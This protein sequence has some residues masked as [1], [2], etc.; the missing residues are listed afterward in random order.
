MET[1][2]LRRTW[3][4]FAVWLGTAQV[5]MALNV[6]NYLSPRNAGRPTRRDTYFIILHTTEGAAKGS[7]NKVWKNGECHYFIDLDGK[8]YRIIDRD[9]VA[10]HAGRSMW[11]GRTSIDDYSIGIEIVGTYNRDITVAQYKACAELLAAL[12]KIYKV[13]D[14]KVLSHCMVAYGAPNRWHSRSHRGRKRC[15]MFLTKDSTRQKLGLTSKPAYDPDVKAGRL[16]NADPTLAAFVYR[17]GGDAKVDM[18]VIKP[19]EENVITKNRS[20]W[21]VA[22]AQY[23]NAKTVYIFPDGRKLRGNEIRDWKNIP[24]GTRVQMDEDMPENE[25]DPVTELGDGSIVMDVAGDEYND[26]STLYVLAS[27]VVKK[28]SEMSDAEFK[29]LPAG[30]KV[31]LGYVEGGA[32]TPKK[33]AFEICGKR[34]NLPATCYL[35]KDGTIKPGNEIKENE[36]Q[37]GTR[38]FYRK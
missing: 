10:L 14:D 31:L 9:K 20:A 34:W 6:V 15:G 1:Y 24:V 11:N 18:P 30:T 32:V 26:E 29:T 33:S 19:G 5:C 17:K 7:L 3:I 27:G 8:V 22:R 21:D 35:L 38:I 13:S 25:E 28:G 37:P 23:R 2:V 4:L 36:I 12:Q 16:V